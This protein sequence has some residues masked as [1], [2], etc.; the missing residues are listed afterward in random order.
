M[1]AASVARTRWQERKAA[2]GGD[3]QALL[4]NLSVEVSVIESDGRLID[5]HQE[6]AQLFLQPGHGVSFERK[7]TWFYRLPEFV[8][9]SQAQGARLSFEKLF[10]EYGYDRDSY[11]RKDFRLFRIAVFTLSL[12]E[13]ATKKAA[14]N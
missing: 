4:P 2:L 5:M 14:L 9:L 1:L 11:A 7:G 6:N 10:Q 12:D 8:N 3:L 13:T